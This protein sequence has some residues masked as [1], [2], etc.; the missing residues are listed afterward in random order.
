MKA[1]DDVNNESIN[2]LKV[3]EKFSYGFGN[4][5]ANLLITTANTFIVYF[6]TEI[7]GIA[8]ATVG[9]MLLLAR[10]FDGLTDLGMGIVVDKTTSKHG[11]AR[12]WLLWMA[13]PYGLAIILLFSAPN[14]G[15]TGTIVYA[16]IT[17]MLALSF[18]YTAATV[19]YNAM[20]GTLTNDQVERGQLS[21]S[22]TAFGFGGA[23]LVNL[24]TLPVVSAYGGGQLGWFLMALTYGVFAS[25]LLILNFK[26]TKERVILTKDDEKLKKTPIKQGIKALVKNKYWLIVISVMLVTFINSGLSGVNVYYAEYILGNPNLVGA[27]GMAQFLPVIIMMLIMGPLMKRFTNKALCITGAI[28][29]IVA[30]FIVLIN[31]DSLTIVMI[32]LV[33][34]GV[35]SAPMLAATFAMLGDTVDYGEWKT[36]VRSEGLTF[37]AATFGE[38]VGTG[39][40]GMLLGVMMG[41]GGYVGG[42]AI[43]AEAALQ[44]IKSV[45]IFVPIVAG[46]IAV[47]LLL[48]Y[49]LDKEHEQIVKE[50][51]SNR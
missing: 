11:K 35:G 32:G 7:A 36:G 43:Q 4:L 49:K 37:S 46:I 50:L 5:A 27:M 9:T 48:F 40:G 23:L 13:I 44:S 28:T 16:F 8:V 12:P 31:P 22:R 34:R 3:R 18:I 42:Q 51:A 29:L 41:I 45:F 14:F 19:P 26:N 10:I 47:L 20:I 39:L 38:K 1:I 33:L 24:V 21:V 2:K 25:I 30:S 15:P 6:Y 17:Y